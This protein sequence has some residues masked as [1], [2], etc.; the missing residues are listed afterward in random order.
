M[1][2]IIGN[3]S[4]NDLLN[5]CSVIASSFESESITGKLGILGPTRIPYKNIIGILKEFVEIMP[6][7]C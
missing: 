1:L 6:N 4:E 3:E 5:H 7:V 2:T